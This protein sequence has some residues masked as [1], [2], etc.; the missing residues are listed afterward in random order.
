MAAEAVGGMGVT[1]VFA[2]SKQGHQGPQLWMPC[3]FASGCVQRALQA[4]K[5]GRIKRHKFGCPLALNGLINHLFACHKFWQSLTWAHP[6][7]HICSYLPR[8]RVVQQRLVVLND[9]SWFWVIT[10]DIPKSIIKSTT[11]TFKSFLSLISSSNLYHSLVECSP[12]MWVAR[13]RF[14]VMHQ[15]RYW[16]FW[17]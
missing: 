3:I 14:P 2:T 1:A 5:K 15:R 13:V 12:A 10:Q 8:R 16:Q 7:A 6:L 9:F 11:W 17:H 4:T